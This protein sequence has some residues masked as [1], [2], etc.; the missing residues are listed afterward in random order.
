MTS[1]HRDRDDD[2]RGL[3]DWVLNDKKLPKGLGALADE[4]VVG[5]G[6]GA[7]GSVGS[8]GV[9]DLFVDC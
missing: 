3:G 1:F 2:K 9:G 6:C 4:A 5:F 8:A 7:G